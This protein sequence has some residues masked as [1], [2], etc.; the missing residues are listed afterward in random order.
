MKLKAVISMML[1]V[2]ILSLGGCG[3]TSSNVD[4]SNNNISNIE[5]EKA[6]KIVKNSFERYF[7][8]KIDSKNYR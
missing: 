7:D 8:L 2:L 4:N 3:T 1:S 5:K 6:V